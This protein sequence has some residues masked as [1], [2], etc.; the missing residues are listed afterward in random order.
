M[1]PITEL[2]IGIAIIFSLSPSHRMQFSNLLGRR[3]LS[4]SFFFGGVQQ[5]AAGRQPSIS[6]TTSVRPFSI[7][8]WQ[9]HIF[10]SPKP[11]KLFTFSPFIVHI[12]STVLNGRKT[13]VSTNGRWEEV[14][15]T[16]ETGGR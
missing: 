5:N 6:L 7:S 8:L 15:W 14:T 12:A 2:S 13:F 10:S 4:L 9:F 11:K 1:Y 16:E 3:K